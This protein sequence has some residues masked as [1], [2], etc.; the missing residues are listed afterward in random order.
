MKS[1]NAT[2]QTGLLSDALDLVLRLTCGAVVITIDRI[3]N[4]ESDEYGRLGAA[5]LIIDIDNSDGTYSTLATLLPRSTITTE[6]GLV[7]AGTT[8]YQADQTWQLLSASNSSFGAFP[9]TIH[10]EARNGWDKFHQLHSN[11]LAWTGEDIG[12]LAGAIAAEYGVTLTHDASLMWD[13]VLAEWSLPKNLSAQLVLGLLLG[14]SPEAHARAYGHESDTNSGLHSGAPVAVLLPIAEYE[15]LLRYKRLM[16][17]D[18]FT[19]EFGQEVERRGL[20]E[21]ELMAELEETKHEVFRE[22]YGRLG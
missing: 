10:L 18:Q 17:F 9:K 6:R 7:I 5:D 14:D 12:T 22:Q 16:M 13:H 20:S 4:W 1:I 15:Q 8:Y 2:L 11:N 3:I 21:E 19:R